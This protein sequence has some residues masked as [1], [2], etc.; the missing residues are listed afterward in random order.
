MDRLKGK[1]AIV[2]GA[3]R[4]IGLYGARKATFVHLTQ[5]RAVEVAPTVRVN[6]GLALTGGL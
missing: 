2:T 5:E 4:V 6:A 1:T 3:S